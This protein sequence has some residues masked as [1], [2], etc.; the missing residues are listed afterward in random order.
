VI[1]S[2]LGPISHYFRYAATYSLKPSIEIC[3]QTAADEDIVT[4]N[5]L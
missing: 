5:S 1:N 4:I 3:G 2:N